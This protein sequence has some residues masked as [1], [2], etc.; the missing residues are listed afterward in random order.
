MFEHCY[1]NVL[2]A[3]AARVSGV[4]HWEVRDP[5]GTGDN[6]QLKLEGGTPAV[7]RVLD[8]VPTVSI[9]IDPGDLLRVVA[10]Q[11]TTSGLM[12]ARRVQVKGDPLLAAHLGYLFS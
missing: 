6:F 11:T 2:A 10:G 9:E 4:V 5:D 3:D 12:M 7:G 1:G 8:L